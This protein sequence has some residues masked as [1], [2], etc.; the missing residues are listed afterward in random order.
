MFRNIKNLGYLITPKKKKNWSRN[1]SSYFALR[2]SFL[3]YSVYPSL[4]PSF[5]LCSRFSLSC[6]S[7]PSLFPFSFHPLRSSLA[8]MATSQAP[9]DSSQPPQ[10]KTLRV[11]I[12]VGFRLSVF[13]RNWTIE[14]ATQLLEGSVEGP[15]FFF[16][17]ELGH[18]SGGGAEVPLWST[19]CHGYRASGFAFQ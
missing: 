11:V 1:A 15:F 16:P 18:C 5:P 2:F 9:N 10:T 3:S 17:W 13:Y 12:K 6:P 14:N 19:G 7:I 8:S 4:H